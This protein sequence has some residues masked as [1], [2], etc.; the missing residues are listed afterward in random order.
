MSENFYKTLGLEENASSGEI[1]K[2]YRS[3]SFKYHPDKNQ[4]NP[5]ATSNFQKI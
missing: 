5:E 4:G 1:K 2:A 3:L